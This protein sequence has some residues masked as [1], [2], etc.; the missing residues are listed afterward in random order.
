MRQTDRVDILLVDDRIDGLI[1][2]EAVLSANPNYNLVKASSGKEALSLLPNY[3]FAVILLDVQMPGLDGFQ[4]AE[5]IKSQSKYKLIPIIFVT[6]ITKDD[7]YVYQGYETG[8][9]DYL[10]KPFDPQILRFKVDVFVQIYIRNRQIALQA[11]LLHEQE[12][13]EHKTYLQSV[14]LKNL[15]RYES[16]ADAIPHMIWR[17]NPDGQM[18]YFNSRWC[19]YTGVSEKTGAGSNWQ[20][21]FDKDDLNRFL[22]F[23]IENM[24]GRR[25]FEIECRIRRYDGSFRWHWIRV[26]AE[27]DMNGDIISWLGTCTDIQDR[28]DTETRLQVAQK[29]A[30][31]ASQAK[32]Q[33]LANMSH[34]IRTPLNAIMGFTELLL[35][36]NQKLE[37]K[38]NSISVV[39]RNCQQLLK[40]I[41]Q[42]LDISK[43]ESGG[44][45]VETLETNILNVVSGVRSLLSITALKKNLTLRFSIEN[46]IPEKVKTDPTRL[47]QILMNIIGNA[48]KFT[49]RGFITTTIK[50]LTKDNKKSFLQFR[51]QD[52]GIGLDPNYV[53]KIFLPFSQADSSTTR[54][55]GGTGLGLSLSRKLA[56]AMGG[57]VWLESS[58]LGSGC[59]FVAEVEAQPIS[60]TRWVTQFS[61]I[62]NYD[63]RESDVVPADL[64]GKNILLVEDAPDNQMLIRRYLQKTGARVDI[65][66]NGKEGV[67]KALKN[68][69]Q[70]V[71]MDIQM[72]LMD[73]YEATSKLRNTGYKKPIIA[74]TAHAFKEERDKCLR[75]GC[76]D[77]LTKPIN[78]KILVE[79]LIK[80]TNTPH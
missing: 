25:D 75:A 69:Y 1:T 35:D 71:L 3:D 24:L 53:E 42:V 10:F 20:H 58:K 63:A 30:E 50:F 36:P 19:R 60:E 78:R 55:F 79:N 77:H 57:D 27:R 62:E 65:A 28:K 47:R 66:N 16:L 26:V 56:R 17:S 8:A 70:V 34:E 6:A 72:P 48:L 37:D 33:F 41:D 18:E 31:M 38:T 80:Y 12:I 40:V 32:T 2:L 45:E 52:T 43:V 11:K 54:M 39:R 15:R 23:W 13:L 9:V 67:E 46:K 29:N 51:I 21:V 64:R 76:N 4:T 74:L 73:G 44:L 61:D 59:C 68:D 14:E 7:R 49:E 22:K 5:I